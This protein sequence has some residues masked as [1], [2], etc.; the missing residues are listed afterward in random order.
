MADHLAEPGTKI[1][2]GSV[3]F[4]F[5]WGEEAAGLR[6]KLG[7]RVTTRCVSLLEHSGTWGTFPVVIAEAGGGLQRAEQ[8]TRDLII[9]RRPRWIIA[10]GFAAGLQAEIAS[11]HIL[12][13]DVI[14]G[15]QGNTWPVEYQVDAAEVAARP[16]LHVGKLLTL[17]TLPGNEDER[18]RLIKTHQALACDT[19][20]QG[21]A[22]VC[23][24]ERVRFL[25]VRIID[26]DPVNGLVPDLQ[27]V[28][29]RTTRSG[30]IGAAARTLFR[31][32]G[33]ILD[34]WQRR[35]KVKQLSDRLARFLVG[36]IK[37]LQDHDEEEQGMKKS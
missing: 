20:T 9:M 3:A 32:P 24:S 33:S 37:R 1:L 35:K 10:A 26:R 27:A 12:M 36:V 29:R 19:H 17:P 16:T 23:Q 15:L 22:N 5:E 6:R 18:Q 30:R 2:A 25:S 14:C 21:V 34:M 4:I 11:G 31:R 13:P 7:H 28:D 8:A